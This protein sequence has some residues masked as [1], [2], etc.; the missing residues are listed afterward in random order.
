[1]YNYKRVNH[2]EADFNAIKTKATSPNYIYG[3]WL[4]GFD[5]LIKKQLK[6]IDYY[7]EIFYYESVKQMRA[8]VEARNEPD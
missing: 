1:M 2:N 5:K 3:Y 4:N 6:I 8:S 7:Y